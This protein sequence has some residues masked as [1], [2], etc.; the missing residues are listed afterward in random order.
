MNGIVSYKCPSCGGG[1]KF[2]PGKG[3]KC[4]YCLS[5][6]TQEQL[7]A[8]NKEWDDALDNEP[9]AQPAQQ[10]KPGEAVVYSCPSCG[11]EV[12]TDATT[13]ATE[14]H[15]CHNPVV[16]SEKLS[17]SFK[18]DGVIPFAVSREQAAER[19][20]GHCGGKRFLPK[21]FYS[22]QQIERLCGVY[23]PYW[24]VDSRVDGCYTARGEIDRSSRVGDDRHVEITAYDVRRAGSVELRDITNSAIKSKDSEI[25]EY[26]LPYDLSKRREFSMTYLSGFLAERRNIERQELADEVEQTKLRLTGQLIRE[27]LSDYSRLLDERVTINTREE[28]WNYSLLPVWVVTYKYLDRIYMYGINGQSGKSFGELPV[29]SKKL[30]IASVLAGLGVGVLVL[31]FLFLLMDEVPL[32]FPLLAAGLTGVIFYTSTNASY[33]KAGAGQTYSISASTKASI[34]DRLDRCTGKRN[35]VERG[36]YAQKSAGGASAMPD[37]AAPAS[38][39]PSPRPN[40]GVR[41]PNLAAH[42]PGNNINNRPGGPRPGRK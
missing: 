38:T 42:R 1:L 23:Y 26:V 40:P 17:G 33:K 16:L 15:Y 34:V 30:T 22:E 41:P 2:I 31:L 12:I 29:D 37:L 36:Y 18:P 39:K 3:F 25:L 35:H 14:C 11:A 32:F 4:E 19:F 20:R 7:D 24:V 28:T 27:G 10:A 6:F 9:T 8:A 21:D 5:V 13:A